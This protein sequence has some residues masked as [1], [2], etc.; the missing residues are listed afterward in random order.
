M[1]GMVDVDEAF[2]RQWVERLRADE[3]RA[4]AVVL[5]GSYARGDAGPW[6]DVDFDV[7]TAGAPR[8]AYPVYLAE[9]LT[10]RL[11]L[12]SVACTP[13]EAWLAG[14]AE[15]E[16]WAFGLPVAERTRLLWAADAAV[17][18]RVDRPALRHPPG[19]VELEDLVGDLGKVRNALARGDDLALRLAA[20]GL[21]GLCPSV[22][23]PLNPPVSA[24]SR[25]E[26]L[27]LVLDFPVA[28]PTYREDLL[29]CLGLTG[30][31]AAP[32]AVAAAAARLVDGVV[33]LARQHARLLGPELPPHLPRYL[34]DG[35][36]ERYLGVDGPA[37]RSG[38][39]R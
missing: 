21:A 18:A 6:S 3:P 10:R 11:V 19:G 24:G 34:A 31:A 5:K 39:R 30:R 28:P 13:L 32:E 23:R 20:Q 37:G 38:G 9:A 12:V 1:S 25:T 7:L 35:T 33:S 8:V 26:A 22:L 4:L 36:L 27:R 15:P 16:A 2:I 29:L 14:A 17:R